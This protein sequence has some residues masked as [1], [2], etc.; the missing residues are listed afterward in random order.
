MTEYAT[1]AELATWLHPDATDPQPPE[2]A[3]LLL[4]EARNTVLDV[5]AGSV[6][7]IDRLTGL[8]TD[9][10]VL[11]AIK[12]AVLQQAADLSTNGIDPQKADGGLRP[13]VASKSL[14]GMSVSYVQNGAAAGTRAA[15]AAGQVSPR[16]WGYLDR[17]GLL[18]S[19]VSTLVVGADVYVADRP[20]DP[21]SGRIIY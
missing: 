17:A 10:A 21:L 9:A 11:V 14:A 3:A 12:S 18:T 20:I 15:L 5:L 2:N 4:R 7:A 19:R 6:Y 16:A 8:P 1:P 13:E